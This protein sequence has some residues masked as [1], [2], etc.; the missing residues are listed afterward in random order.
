ML[1]NWIL[2]SMLSI[3]VS[4]LLPTLVLLYLPSDY[5]SA[6]PKVRSLSAFRIFIIIVC[7]IAGI[8]LFIFGVVLL[9]LPGQGLITMLVGI[10][11]TSVPGKKRVIRL[12]LSAKVLKKVNAFRGRF[13]RLPLKTLDN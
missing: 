1:Q 4:L 12:L 8:S 6:E 3:F 11:L 10:M 5:L 9:F 13:G 7:N 2:I